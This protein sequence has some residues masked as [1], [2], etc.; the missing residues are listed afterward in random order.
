VDYSYKKRNY[1]GIKYLIE[2]LNQERIDY[3]DKRS[4]YFAIINS[5]NQEPFQ[6][7]LVST[8]FKPIQKITRVQNNFVGYLSNDKN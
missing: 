4:F 2:G 3:L 6:Q 8:L 5:P 7:L 1:E